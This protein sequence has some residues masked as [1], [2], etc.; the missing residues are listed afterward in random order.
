MTCH[1]CQGSFR[2]ISPSPFPNL[3]QGICGF[4]GEI[5]WFEGPL[6]YSPP[7][8]PLEIEL[9]PKL[10]FSEMLILSKIAQGEII[11]E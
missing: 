2:V 11:L 7:Y 8:P 9:K 5:T 4:C 3:Y 10:N 6:E 1:Y